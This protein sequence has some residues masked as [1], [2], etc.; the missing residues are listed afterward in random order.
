[1]E[2]TSSGYGTQL[3]SSSV[4]QQTITYKPSIK[5]KNEKPDELSNANTVYSWEPKIYEQAT[6][7][8]KTEKVVPKASDFFSGLNNQV[9]VM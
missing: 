3:S 2:S 9:K 4:S 8:V 7:Q 5:M 6:S 1:M